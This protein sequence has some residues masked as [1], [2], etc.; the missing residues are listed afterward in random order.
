MPALQ[1][2]NFPEDL[3]EQLRVCAQQEH[4]SIAQQTIVAV[5]WYLKNK[6]AGSSHAQRTSADDDYLER[7]RKVFEEIDSMPYFEVPEGFPTTAE[8]I[9]ED[10]D[11]R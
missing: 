6:V 9:R 2:R 1:V 11:N 8:L 5:Q 3:Y 10:R 4:R 7:R